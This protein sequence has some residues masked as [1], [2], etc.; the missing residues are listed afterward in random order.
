LP[1]AG[2]SVKSNLDPLLWHDCHE[3]GA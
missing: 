2:C 3:H 1:V